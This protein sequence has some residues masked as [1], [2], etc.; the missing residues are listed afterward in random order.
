MVGR[1]G[2]QNN[3]PLPKI[4]TS[5]I[6]GTCEYIL[7]RGRRDFARVI[8]LEIFEVRLF[9]II[10]MSPTC[11]SKR[12]AGGSEKERDVTME[13]EDREMRGYK[14]GNSGVL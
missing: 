6:P 13:A 2:L 8:K 14:M 12:E 5:Q 1:C 9:C 7:L 4:S 10:H 3:D 11:P